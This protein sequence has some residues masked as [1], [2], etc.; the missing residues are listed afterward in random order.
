MHDVLCT[1]VCMCVILSARDWAIDWRE[2]KSLM[3]VRLRLTSQIKPAVNTVLITLI[4]LTFTRLLSLSL[5]HFL[6]C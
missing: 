2:L 1:S 6:H 4:S 3:R 5:N